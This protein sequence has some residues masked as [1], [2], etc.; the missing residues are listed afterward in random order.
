VISH[1]TP[2]AYHF[3]SELSVPEGIAVLIQPI[4]GKTFNT[5]EVPG[6]EKVTAYAPAWSLTMQ[7]GAPI[8]AYAVPGLGNPMS[9][10]LYETQK[11]FLSGE[12][13]YDKKK[14]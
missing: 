11:S 3:R 4:V 14:I 9:N 6:G 5:V 12:F 8:Q 13:S 1:E 7:V 2:E 10:F